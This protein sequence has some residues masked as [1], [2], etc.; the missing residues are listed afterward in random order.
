MGGSPK[1]TIK[2]MKEIASGHKGECLSTEYLNRRTKLK[3]K[4]ARGHIFSMLPPSKNKNT[5]CLECAKAN[6]SR[7][8]PND[9]DLFRCYKCKQYKP[10]TAFN[11]QAPNYHNKH[12]V[13]GICKECRGYHQRKFIVCIDCGVKVECQTKK[14]KRCDECK[15]QNKNRIDR[16][17]HAKKRPFGKQNIGRRKSRENPNLF[18]CPSCKKYKDQTS[19]YRHKETRS[20]PN[21]ISTYCIECT[22]EKWKKKEKDK[23]ARRKYLKRYNSSFSGRFAIKRN[24]AEHIHDGSSARW[25]KEKRENLSDVYVRR[26][27]RQMGVQLITPELVQWER[28]RIMANRKF[29]ELKGVKDYVSMDGNL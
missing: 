16:V 9:P 5:W 24:S 22:K 10:R 12:G 6:R 17:Y 19:F 25:A 14:M 2:E 15:R 21:G 7:V 11:R 28:E 18:W 27:L 20:K 3:W 13:V 23:E 4:C 29:R 8:H 1:R 26:V